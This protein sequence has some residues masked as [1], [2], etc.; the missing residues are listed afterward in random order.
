MLHTAQESLDLDPSEAEGDLLGSFDPLSPAA[1]VWGPVLILPYAGTDDALECL[2]VIRAD[3]G[4]E[5]IRV[6]V[7]DVTGLRLD[8]LEVTG[9]IR[10]TDTIEAAQLETVIAGMRNPAR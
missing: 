3:L 4:P 8:A 7:I 6:V 9:L 5:Q 10:L 1:H 2:E